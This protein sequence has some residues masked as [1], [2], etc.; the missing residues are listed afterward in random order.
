[1]MVR[2][3]Y[4]VFRFAPK[5]DRGAGSGRRGEERFASARMVSGL[6]WLAADAKCCFHLSLSSFDCVQW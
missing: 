6:R 4:S 2:R 5:G 1:M 3:C